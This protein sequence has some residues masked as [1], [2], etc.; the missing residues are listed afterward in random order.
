MPM[1]RAKMMSRA[2]T[3]IKRAEKPDAGAGQAAGNGA[4]GTESA[5]IAGADFMLSI[6]E[7]HNTERMGMS[8]RWILD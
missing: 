7:T 3:K 5:A 2:K 8:S 6:V 1:S 4:N